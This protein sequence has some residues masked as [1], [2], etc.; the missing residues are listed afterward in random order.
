M[1]WVLLSLALIVAGAQSQG[2]AKHEV[3]QSNQSTHDT[4]A[5]QRETSKVP[6]VVQ[7]APT[8]QLNV[9]TDG[10]PEKEHQKTRNETTLAYS[11]LGL[12]VITFFLA[13]F[14]LGLMV[15]T[16]KLWKA[17]KRLV[18]NTNETAERQLRAYAM[19]LRVEIASETWP[20]GVAQS[21]KISV[22][23]FGKTPATSV[24]YWLYICPKSAAFPGPLARPQLMHDM[25]AGV[26]APGDT[27]TTRA[28]IPMLAEGDEISR[29][30]YALYV[31]GAFSYKDAFNQERITNF[32]FM[33]SG[34]HW[35]SEGEME[36]CEAGNEI[37]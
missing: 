23:N 9:K 20:D 34:E 10:D 6:L 7:A 27:F 24:R 14:T 3:S 21:I 29:S 26:I 17:T 35:L 22:K 13:A 25:T 31:Y 28:K 32:R 18:E 5:H 37:T 8:S 36:T 30:L 4:S 19:V 2:P 15:F 33:R 12:A 1:R 11:T 16:L